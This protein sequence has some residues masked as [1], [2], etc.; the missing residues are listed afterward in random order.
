MLSLFSATFFSVKH[1]TF[2]LHYHWTVTRY[3]FCNW[4]H[5]H[6]CTARCCGRPVSCQ[7]CPG[8]LHI[9]EQKRFHSSKM[10]TSTGTTGKNCLLPLND[11]FFHNLLGQLCLV[12]ALSKYYLKKCYSISP[13]YDFIKPSNFLDGLEAW[14]WVK[15]KWLLLHFCDI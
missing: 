7:T 10:S 5:Q 6:W 15:P 2:C 9:I 14:Q 1:A 4:P 13:C 3:T 8:S 11:T 12:E